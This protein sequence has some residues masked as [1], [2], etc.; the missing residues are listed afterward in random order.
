MSSSVPDILQRFLSRPETLGTRQEEIPPQERWPLLLAAVSGGADSIALFDAL[1]TLREPLQFRLEIIHVHH[2]LRGEAADQDAA[3]VR[4]L[5]EQRQVPFHLERG[6]TR[7]LMTQENLS[8]EEAARA[9]RYRAFCQIATQRHATAVVVAHHL[10]DDVET[11]LMRL[12]TGAS[13]QGLAGMDEITWRQSTAIWRPFLRTPQAVLYR[14]LQ[15]R[16]LPWRFDASNL[17]TGHLR[18]RI[19]QELLPRLQTDFNPQVVRTLGKLLQELKQ[20]RTMELPGQEPGNALTVSEVG[21][22]LP[23]GDEGLHIGAQLVPVEEW[24]FPVAAVQGLEQRERW[25]LWRAVLRG[26]GIPPKELQRSLFDDLDT[27][28]SRTYGTL[29]IDLPGGLEARRTYGTLIFGTRQVP[30]EPPM[31]VSLS[32]APWSWTDRYAGWVLMAELLDGEVPVVASPLQLG[33][34]WWERALFQAQ[35]SIPEITSELQIRS[36]Q[37]GDTLAL[38][39]GGHTSLKE[40]FIDQ[41]LPQLFRERWPVIALP[42]GDIL[43]VPGWP[44]AAVTTGSRSR[45]WQFTAVKTAHWG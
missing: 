43:W 6:D 19:R 35:V 8:M 17:E 27:L 22:Q 3:F 38:P 13:L 29:A 32:L 33:K 12:M 40:C 45:K 24:Q 42:E 44:P 30:D 5:A 41:K 10:D 15:A 16:Q 21:K 9:I 1:D 34:R 4:R 20:L 39:Q 14:H 37:P 25:A 31:P 11:L 36:R 23:I 7:A 18:N 2:G 28:I 26:L